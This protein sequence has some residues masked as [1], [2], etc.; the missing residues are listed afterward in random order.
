MQQAEEQ[1]WKLQLTG[2]I[3]PSSGLCKG[4]ELNGWKRSKKMIFY[5]NWKLQQ[6]QIFVSI[7]KFC[8]NTV[9][10]I[11]VLSVTVLHYNIRIEQLWQILYGPQSQK[12]LLLVPL[13]KMFAN[14]CNGEIID[15]LPYKHT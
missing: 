6:I 9:T 2:Q 1:G 3:Q 5:Y 12:Y 13:Q 11:H 10:F 8:W 4:H 15:R 7:I 14:P